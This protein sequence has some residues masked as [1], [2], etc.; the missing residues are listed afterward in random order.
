M[1]ARRLLALGALASLAVGASACGSGG[2]DEEPTPAAPTA[3]QAS[4]TPTPKVLAPEGMTPRQTPPP[5]DPPDP[6]DFPGMEEQTEDGAQQAFAYYWAVAITA[7]QSGDTSALAQLGAESCDACAQYVDQ[8]TERVE[9]DQ[10]WPPAT[11]TTE[12]LEKYEDTDI[13]NVVLYRFTVTFEEQEGKRTPDPASYVSV[14]GLEWT[15]GGWKVLDFA[16][17]SEDE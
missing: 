14:G 16:L 15:D 9:K 12:V 8:V 10:L 1:I 2:S 11:V 6:A 13:D 5:V 7:N 17:Q 3:Q 4:P